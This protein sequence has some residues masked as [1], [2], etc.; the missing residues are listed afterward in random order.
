MAMSGLNLSAVSAVVVQIRVVKTS[1][2]AK[3]SFIMM[4]SS[5]D[6]LSAV[7]AGVL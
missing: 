7:V 1:T 6:W 2:M 5:K 4:S 3:R